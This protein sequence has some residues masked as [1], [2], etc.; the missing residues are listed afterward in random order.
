MTL[1]IAHKEGDKVVIDRVLERKPPFSP[2][3]VVDEFAGVLK[4]YRIKAVEGD[5]YGGE[6]PREPF[7]KTSI[8]YEPASQGEV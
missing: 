7:R 4:Q 2:A 1:A 5:R 3:R 8:T 6:W